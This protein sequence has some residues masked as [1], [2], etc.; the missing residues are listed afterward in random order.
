ML[1]E[2]KNQDKN[3]INQI[4]I[5]N[6]WTVYLKKNYTQIRSFFLKLRRLEPPSATGVILGTGFNM[7]PDGLDST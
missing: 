2:K 5:R 4:V 3:E 1:C 6:Y 7:H